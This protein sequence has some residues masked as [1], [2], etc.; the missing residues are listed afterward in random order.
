LALTDKGIEDST[1]YR[2]HIP[3]T[4]CDRRNPQEDADG[5]EWCF[6]T[7]NGTDDNCNSDVDEGT[8]ILTSPMLDACGEF[9]A[10]VSYYRWYSNTEGSYPE[11]G[12]FEVEVSDDGGANWTPLETV[13]PDGPEVDGGWFHKEFVVGDF[14]EVTDAFRIRFKA[15]DLNEQSIV[16]AAVDG[17]ELKLI[18]CEGLPEDI[19]GDG[20]I[21]TEDLLLLL[22]AWGPCPGCPEDINGDGVVNTEDLLLLLGAWR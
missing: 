6:L 22:A 1:C 19:N 7:D 15:S 12:I 9:S 11:A 8:T 4:D 16:E 10:L 3:N 13:G 20:V 18:D 21:N 5:S 14:V 17:I 2:P